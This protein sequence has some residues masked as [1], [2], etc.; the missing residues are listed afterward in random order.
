MMGAC[1]FG[2]FGSSSLIWFSASELNGHDS[3]L[4]AT[5]TFNV[6][7]LDRSGRNSGAL[8]SL[9]VITIFSARNHIDGDRF[10]EGGATKLKVDIIGVRALHL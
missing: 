6:I 9:T 8:C 10:C 4:V 2:F 3:F 7:N 1:W 5:Y